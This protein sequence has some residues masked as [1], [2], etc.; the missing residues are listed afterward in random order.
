MKADGLGYAFDIAVIIDNKSNWNKKVFKD[1]ADSARELMK[2]YNI[3]WGGDWKNFSDYPHF[4][5]M[6]K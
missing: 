2:K 1:V 6:L 5:L 3:E 4:Q